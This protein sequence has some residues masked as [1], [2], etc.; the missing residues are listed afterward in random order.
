KLGPDVTGLLGFVCKASGCP[1]PPP[2]NPTVNPSPVGV[3]N[4]I[5]F[6]YSIYNQGDPVTGV[7]FTDTVQGTSSTITSATPRVGTTTGTSACTVSSHKLTA[8]CN[9]G[10]INTSATTTTSIGSTTTSTTAAATTVQVIVTANVPSSTGVTPPKPPDVGNSAT[11]SLTGV[12]FTPQTASGSASVNDFG[13][14]AVA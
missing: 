3:G 2:A 13:V 9:L 11:L 12:S 1:T 14:S 4:T 6:T 5:T 10:T 8:L 7:L